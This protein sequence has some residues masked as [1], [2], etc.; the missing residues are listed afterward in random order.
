MLTTAELA[1]AVGTTPR[2]VLAIA[3]RRGVKP[4][5]TIGRSHLWPSSAVAG[6]R[7]GPKGWPKGKPRRMRT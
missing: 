6:L 4:A 2:G 7:P 3:K 5:R 1:A